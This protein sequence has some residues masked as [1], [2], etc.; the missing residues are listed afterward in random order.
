MIK[1]LSRDFGPR[2]TVVALLL[3]SVLRRARA[4]PCTITTSAAIDASFDP[5][6]CG[7]TPE[8]KQGKKWCGQK[9]LNYKKALALCTKEKEGGSLCTSDQIEFG[10][11]TQTGC[12]LDSTRVW[13]S[14]VCAVKKGKKTTDG[15][16]MRSVGFGNAPGFFTCEA[17][18]K[19]TYVR[20]CAPTAPT[21]GEVAGVELVFVFSDTYDLAG[22]SELVGAWHL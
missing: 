13:T 21:D 12:N 19:K 6:V 11:A 15:H 10:E 5:D 4:E 9:K 16:I 8:R 7:F 14:T 22:V 17:D 3:C 1:C 2:F 20:C 18:T